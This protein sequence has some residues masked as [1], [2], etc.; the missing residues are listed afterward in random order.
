M[1]IDGKKEELKK[2]KLG[3]PAARLRDHG[4]G[5]RKNNSKKR[6]ET[7]TH[8]HTRTKNQIKSKHNNNQVRMRVKI[9]EKTRYTAV[10]PVETG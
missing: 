7:H 2:N 1:S 8:T 6:G 4:V 9:Q 10:H 3:E 5:M